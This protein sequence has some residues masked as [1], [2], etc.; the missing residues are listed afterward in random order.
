M[1][2]DKARLVWQAADAAPLLG[3]ESCFTAHAGASL[4]LGVTTETSSQSL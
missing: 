2:K 4:L 1:W 3:N